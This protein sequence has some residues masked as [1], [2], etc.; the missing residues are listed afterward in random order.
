[1]INKNIFDV[2]IVGAGHNGLVSAAYLAKS[3]LRVLVLE[4]SHKIGGASST[5]EFSEGFR[6]SECAHLLYGLHPL[7]VN[8]LQL[9]N[10]GLS[11]AA[12]D[13]ETVSLGSDGKHVYVNGD[14]ASGEI[15]TTDV[16]NYRDFHATMMKFC[17]VFGATL[18]QR[19][20]RL[21]NSSLRDK[22][23]YLKLGWLV[24]KLGKIDMQ[25][26]L[27]VGS[28][29]IYDVL[30]ENFDNKLLK[31]AL[32]LDSVLGSHT[33][34]RSPNTVLAYLYRHVGETFGFK[35]ASIPVGGMG[36]V[37]ESI[38]GSAKSLGA[39]LRT[40]SRVAQILT[41]D[42]RVIGVRLEGGEEI[43]ANCVVSNVDPKS[44]FSNLV[45]YPL[46]DTDFSRRVSNIRM[47][48]N[49]AKLH[50][51]LDALPQ[52]TGVGE[53]KIGG[54]LV[55]APDSDY[56]ERAF[57]HAKYKEYSTKPVIEINIPS[58][59]DASLAPEGKHV[60]S[61][62]VQYAPHD[63]KEGWSEGNEQFK[64]LVIDQIENYAPGLKQSIL[65]SELLSPADIEARFG[66]A[67]GH[68]HHGELAL[69]QFF[70]LR[71]FPGMSQYTTPVNGLYLCSA[72]SHPGGNVMG[73]V[74]RNCAKTVISEGVEL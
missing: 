2:V 30:E 72:G 67:G 43:G 38:A 15:S 65:A 19:P 8:D 47:K 28:I 54:R 29:N 34:P 1:M 62:V 64:N 5:S 4:A 37:A 26:L 32:S 9:E 46:M 68:W 22:L 21:I 35:G 14:S 12:T 3:G 74:G 17:K 11:Y 61:A 66:T 39:E 27:R 51:A 44:T 16:K 33:G 10:H 53:D 48:G 70:M 20:P 41:E 69:D 52:F 18:D 42:A 57:N 25:E 36:A 6:V 73:L 59:N 49:T 23:L 13:L 50:L 71:P 63:L 55:I 7:I 31:G 60:L 24:K 56:V 58:V 45:G 40:E